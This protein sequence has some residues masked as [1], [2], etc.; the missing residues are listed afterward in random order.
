MRCEQSRRK[1]LMI[2]KNMFDKNTIEELPLE[3]C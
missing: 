1:G 3:H 2:V